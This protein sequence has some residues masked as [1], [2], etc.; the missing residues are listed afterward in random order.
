M[1]FVIVVLAAVLLGAVAATPQAEPPRSRAL[2]KPWAGRLVNGVRLPAA[3]QDF[4]T[5][6]EIRGRSPNRPGR[7]WGT[8]A[9]VLLIERV[10]LEYR[11]A[12]PDAPPL[13]VGD[14]SRPRGGNFG[15]GYGG[16]G[17]ASHQN[18]LDVDVHYPRRDRIPRSAWKPSQVDGAL[19]QELVDRFVDAG[20]ERV[21]VGPRLG[22]RGPRRIVSALV[23]HDDHLHVRIPNPRRR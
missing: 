10:A 19:A 11:S 4:L 12:H 3:G 20:A 5:W 17:H 2:G 15:P 18:G 16:L 8:D 14:L 9:L 22:L 7:R 6:D 1:R 21:F 13:L 23:H